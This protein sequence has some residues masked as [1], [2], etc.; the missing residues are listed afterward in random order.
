M[1]IFLSFTSIYLLEGHIR[2]VSIKKDIVLS[3]DI[4]DKHLPLVSNGRKLMFK[5]AP[6]VDQLL[7]KED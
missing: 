3:I 6:S 1:L 4:K 5:D 2:I 7:S